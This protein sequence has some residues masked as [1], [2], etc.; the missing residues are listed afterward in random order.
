MVQKRGSKLHSF[1]LLLVYSYWH[2]ENGHKKKV[3]LLSWKLYLCSV[4]YTV[5]LMQILK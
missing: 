5:N 3:Q 4:L 1:G 2:M